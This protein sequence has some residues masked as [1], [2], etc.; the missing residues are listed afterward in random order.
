MT[1]PSAHGH[2]AIRHILVPHDSAL[3]GQEESASREVEEVVRRVLDATA[4][5][6]G[7]EV[8]RLLAQSLLHAPGFTLR[9]GTNEV[10]RGVVAREL[11]L[12]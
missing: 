6:Q 12:R 9:G 5:P 1:F 11:G 3:G 10:L 7:S 2:E 8:E 4:D